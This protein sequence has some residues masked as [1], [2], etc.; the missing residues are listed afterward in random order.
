MLP[1][2][3]QP[4]HFKCGGYNPVTL[5]LF[6]TRSLAL[7]ETYPALHSLQLGPDWTVVCRFLPRARMRKRG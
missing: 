3:V 2:I 6:V 1:R 4:D 7:A 5:T